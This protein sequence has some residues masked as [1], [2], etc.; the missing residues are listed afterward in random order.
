MK[1]KLLQLALGIVTALM[2]MLAIATQAD[3]ATTPFFKVEVVGK[4]KQAM[5]F[6]PGLTCPGEV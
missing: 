5:I 3:A 1:I 4:G 6:I 2:A